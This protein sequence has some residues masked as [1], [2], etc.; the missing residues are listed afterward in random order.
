MAMS[1]DIPVTIG[2]G[3]K[4]RHVKTMVIKEK[5]TNTYGPPVGLNMAFASD[6]DFICFDKATQTLF[7]DED[8]LIED[9]K[10]NSCA[11]RLFVPAKEKGY[12]LK[13]KTKVRERASTT[14]PRSELHNFLPKEKQRKDDEPLEYCH[15]V[16]LQP[17]NED[18]DERFLKDDATATVTG[19]ILLVVASLRD[20]DK[21]SI[22]AAAAMLNS[23][24]KKE[25]NKLREK[26]PEIID[27]IYF[28]L[29][30]IQEPSAREAVIGAVC[31]L[32]EKHTEEAISSL[33][34]LSLLCDRHITQIW[35]AL[36]QA[37]Q[38]V[39]LQVLAKL[40]EVL[41]RK[42]DFSSEPSESDSKFKD[43][44]LLPLAATKALCIIFRDK[45]CKVPMNSFYVS[46]II[47]LVIQLHYLN[48]SEIDYGQED[49]FKTS[50]YISC[51]MEALKALIKREKTPQ[52]CFTSLTGSWDLLSSPENY[53]EG[54]LLLARALVKHHSGL[55]YAVFTKVIPLLHH[56]DDKQK[57]TAMAF[58]TA[59][60][61]SD[62]TYTVLQK[63]YI[64]GLLKNW[65]TDSRATYRW[66]SLNGLGNVAHHLQN[67]EL[68]ALILG[69]LPSFND[70]DEKVALTAM[71]VITKIVAHHKNNV[72]V[73][74][75][76]TEQ[77]QPFL[78]DTRSKISCA[79]NKLFQDILKSIDVKD[80]SIMQDHVLTS[81]VTLMVNLQDPHQDVV[82]SRRGSLKEC[83]VFQGWTIHDSQD[84]WDTI[85]KRLVREHP[86]KLRS[87]LIQAQDYRQSPRKSSSSAATIFIDSILYHMELSPVQRSE[88]DFLKQA[89]SSCPSENQHPV[90]VVLQPEKVRR[91]WSDLFRCS[92]YFPK[93]CF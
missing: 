32:A 88:V 30:A 6:P 28:H 82:K 91:H 19:Q 49:I 2:P 37:K 17:D 34:R 11:A 40:L 13:T 14:Q 22:Q 79:A 54:V 15:G 90:P 60:L 73:Y 93:S 42:P 39:R 9:Q 55:D 25:M 53:L 84:S 33:L 92:R 58:F 43:N 61:S 78:A 65:Q 31:L 52:T 24:L 70:P 72:N 36:G 66:L 83:E 1:H 21:T 16:T 41:K 62:S 68:T 45:K 18:V 57:L 87:F 35:E 77:L 89:F 75:K 85:C 71:E 59:L 69:I 74:V 50:S 3:V 67:K 56:G 47:F 64:L 10:A 27:I 38:T 63:H 81:I 4:P 48:C 46:V 80:K 23:I 5:T 44:S 7:E 8:D 29:R 86:E 76:I 26:V 51:T 12:V 20:A